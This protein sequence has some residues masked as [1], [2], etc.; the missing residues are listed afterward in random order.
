MIVFDPSTVNLISIRYYRITFLSYQLGI[1]Q[2]AFSKKQV[3]IHE[4]FANT[5]AMSLWN[6]FCVIYFLVEY[7]HREV[8]KEGVI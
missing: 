4:Y 1:L 7:Y 2:E 8:L 3:E 6:N 5:L